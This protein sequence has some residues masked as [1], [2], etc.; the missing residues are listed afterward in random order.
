MLLLST[1][2]VTS[3]HTGLLEMRVCHEKASQQTVEE[4]KKEFSLLPEGTM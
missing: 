4:K 2:I 1:F 3:R